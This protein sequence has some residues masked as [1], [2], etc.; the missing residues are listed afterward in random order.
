MLDRKLKKETTKIRTKKKE[1]KRKAKGRKKERKKEE[2]KKE[3]KKERKKEKKKKKEQFFL[4]FKN[5]LIYK[6]NTKVMFTI[7]KRIVYVAGRPT[8][9][10]YGKRKIKPFTI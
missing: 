9:S 5:E 8:F 7:I 6:L 2:K 4:L 10:K 1:R 3:R